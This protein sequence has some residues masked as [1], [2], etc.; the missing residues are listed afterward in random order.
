MT[1]WRSGWWWLVVLSV[2]PATER[3]GPARPVVWMMPPA[4]P[5]GRCFRELFTR[6]EAWAETRRRVDVVGYADHNLNRQ[7]NDAELGAWLP[8]LARW[9]IGLGLEVG[10]V[11]PWGPT[12]R[13][14]FDAQRPMWDRFQRLGG[15]ITALAMDEPLVCARD[16]LKKPTAYAVEETARFIALVREHYPSVRIGDVEP[17]PSIPLPALV[18]WIDA[19]QARLASL[20]VRGLD[21]FRLDVDWVHFTVEGRGGWPEVKAL[22][23]ACRARKVPFSLIYWA[24]DYPHMKRLGLADDAWWTVGVLRQGADY[25]VVGGRPD[26]YVVE[27]WVG[28]PAHSVPETDEGTF[29]RSVRDF[30]RRFVK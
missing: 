4:A 26:E 14:T 15:R 9:N 21:F 19:L 23:E 11:K 18:A 8:A 28:A 25:A 3:A 17:Y 16:D 20:H 7:F 22:E 10:A 6:P 5:D 30:C 13:A 24:A 2:L 12:G 1:G 29:T 27:S